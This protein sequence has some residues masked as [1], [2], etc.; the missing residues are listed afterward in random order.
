MTTDHS[1]KQTEQQIIAKAKTSKALEKMH[2]SDDEFN[3][4]WGDRVPLKVIMLK[5]VYPDMPFLAKEDTVCK[6]GEEYYCWVNSYG[7]VSAILSNGDQLGLK[8]KEFVVT[9]YH[10]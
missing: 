5:T 10:K 7:A 6:R 9:E 3:Y 4:P 1:G 2:F 8:P